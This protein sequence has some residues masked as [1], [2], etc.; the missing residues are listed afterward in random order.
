VLDLASGE[1]RDTARRLALASDVVIDN[2]SARVMDGFG[3]GP[4]VLR[5]A[6]PGLVVVRMTGFGLTGP[7]RDHVSYGPTLQARAGYTA[8]MTAP[9]GAP[10]GFGY[11]YADVAGGQLAALAVLAAL[12]RRQRTGAGATIDFS[13]LE[14]V[15]ALLGPLLLERALDGGR[16]MPPGNASQEGPAAPHGVY[17]C[18]GDDRWLALAV[19]TEDEWRRFVRA[20]GSPGWADD[21][22]LATLEGRM[23]HG[24]DLDR[25]VGAWTRTQDADAAM[26]LLQE[27]GVAA[28]RVAD[29]VDL[30]ERDPQLAARGHF[31]SVPTPEGRTVRLDSPA[32]RLS[33]TPVTPTA[34]GPLLGEHTAEVLHALAS[35]LDSAAS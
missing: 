13:Q 12:W 3:L 16:S 17:P 32:F 21:P 6:R 5:A 9:D 20:I 24:G 31:V 35:V 22:R 8:L 15:T 2:F 18:A 14:A 1:G 19:F 7:D 10:I 26:A 33:E 23:A 34:P 27:A 11:S 28:G 25:L 30:C 4:E 29:A